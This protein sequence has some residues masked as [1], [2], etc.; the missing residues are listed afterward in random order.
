ME[1]K[2]I[3]EIEEKSR[4]VINKFSDVLEKITDKNTIADYILKNVKES[5]NCEIAT[6]IINNEMANPRDFEKEY[7]EQEEKIK[8]DDRE[9]NV[10]NKEIK[11]DDKAGQVSAVPDT[12]PVAEVSAP[13]VEVPK[14][15]TPTYTNE[16]LVEFCSQASQLGLGSKVKEI[17][18]D[19]FGVH[20]VSD[21]PDEKREDFVNKLR[22][23]GVRI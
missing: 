6:R 7:E 13:T 9:N 21:L 12:S 22:E 8:V 18:R 1:I 11:V 14:A 5:S 15:T 20:K 16:Q 19:G 23:L 17:I 2:I 3:F 4:S 10:E